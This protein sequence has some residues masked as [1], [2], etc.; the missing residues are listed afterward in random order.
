MTDNIKDI[1]KKGYLKAILKNEYPRYISKDF[2]KRV[3]VKI[4]STQKLYIKTYVLRVASAF[5]FGIF[6]LF[7]MDSF[8]T[9]EIQYSET[10]IINESMQPSKNVSTDSEDCKNINDK[11]L[12]SDIIECK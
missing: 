2:S 11:D 8:L 12:A 5:I 9:K 4:L 1:E 3:M 10:N 7:I 6:T